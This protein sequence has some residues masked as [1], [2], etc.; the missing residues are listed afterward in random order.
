MILRSLPMSKLFINTTQLLW[1]APPTSIARLRLVQSAYPGQLPEPTS[2]SF[3]NMFTD[4]IHGFT[5][6]VVHFTCKC[7][8][9]ITPLGD[10]P[11]KTFC[12]DHEC[13]AL[14]LSPHPRAAHVNDETW[15]PGKDSVKS[16]VGDN[17][18]PPWLSNGTTFVNWFRQSSTSR[19]KPLEE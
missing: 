2:V 10:M 15:F 9:K 7:L 16:T 5:M 17:Q 18:P 11:K 3:A 13:V 19:P 4:L 8:S 12:S 14:T 6:S 1:G